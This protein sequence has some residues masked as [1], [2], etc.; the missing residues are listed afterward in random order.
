MSTGKL[1]KRDASIH[2]AAGEDITRSGSPA[3]LIWLVPRAVYRTAHQYVVGGGQ[4]MP[5]SCVAPP[6]IDH[7]H[8]SVERLPIDAAPPASSP[9]P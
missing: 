3:F 5:C 8:A 4:E 1:M 2:A 6:A 7:E 9:L